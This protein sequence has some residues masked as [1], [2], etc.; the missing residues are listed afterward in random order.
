MLGKVYNET[1]DIYP[2]PVQNNLASGK[3]LDRSDGRTKAR[4]K[5]EQCLGREALRT[6]QGKWAIGWCST[7]IS[8]EEWIIQS[9]LT[10]LQ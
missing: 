1:G 9:E 10:T 3:L 4:E 8:F 6:Y 2:K 7:V 5:L